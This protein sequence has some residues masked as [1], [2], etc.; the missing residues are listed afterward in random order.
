[1]T[2][3]ESDMKLKSAD[4]A[5]RFL[6]SRAVAC[7]SPWQRIAQSS[8]TGQ[9]TYWLYNS[10]HAIGL[11]ERWSGYC[12][13]AR[14]CSARHLAGQSFSNLREDGRWK[15]DNSLRIYLDAV[16]S[17][18]EDDPRVTPFLPMVEQ[19]ESSFFWEWYLL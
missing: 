7:K 11:P 6:L 17:I 16:A 9:Y 10:A 15:S 2:Q 12:P 14:W 5:T 8:S 19:L 18:F 4:A 13:W 3:L 1:M